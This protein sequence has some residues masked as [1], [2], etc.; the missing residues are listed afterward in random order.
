M[1][2]RFSVGSFLAGGALEQFRNFSQ[3]IL[4]LHVVFKKVEDP[5]RNQGFG[6]NTVRS[7]DTDELKILHDGLHHYDGAERSPPKIP[8]FGEKSYDPI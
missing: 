7:K 3:V 6:Y 5:L 8:P 4:S 1:S 2:F